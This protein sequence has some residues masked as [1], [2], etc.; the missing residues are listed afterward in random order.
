MGLSTERKVFVA[1]LSI[2]GAALVI[3]QGLLGPSSAEAAP[4]LPT[5]EATP[6]LAG[7]TSAST[8]AAQQSAAQI[9]IDRLTKQPGSEKP[10]PQASLSTAF[11]LE[12]LIEPVMEAVAQQGTPQVVENEP[13]QRPTLPVLMPSNLDFPTLSAVMPAKTGGGAV[14]NGKLVRVGQVGPLGFT[15]KQ[16][17]ER[18]VV[19]Q[20][21]GRE[22]TVEIPMHTG[23]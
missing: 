21:D 20:L 6:L 7:I 9:L 2:A 12:E 4:P 23:P 22:Y 1:I 15:L 11:S 10:A 3:D 13:Q 18:G 8:P 14:L 16:V 17:R 5:E 19:L